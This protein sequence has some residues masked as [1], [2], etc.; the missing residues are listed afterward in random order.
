M[1]AI[2]ERLYLSARTVDNPLTRIYAKLGVRG[3]A[4]LRELLDA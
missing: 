4:E 2:A 1:A 3:R